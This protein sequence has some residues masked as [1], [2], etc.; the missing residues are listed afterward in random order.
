MGQ[1]WMRVCFIHPVEGLYR[2]KMGEKQGKVKGGI[3]FTTNEILW[4][5]KKKDKYQILHLT[6]LILRSPWSAD[7]WFTI[8]WKN[9]WKIVRPLRQLFQSSWSLEISWE[10]FEKWRVLGSTQIWVWES[11]FLIRF[12]YQKGLVI[13]LSKLPFWGTI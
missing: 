3:Y 4:R 9:L 13:K 8:W 6:L 1:L 11:I 10:A 12:D 7:S 5:Q 2:R